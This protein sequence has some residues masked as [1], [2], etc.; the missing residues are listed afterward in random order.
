MRRLSHND[1]DKGAREMGQRCMFINGT[2]ASVSIHVYT[3][4][5]IRL[6]ELV[7]P[8]SA[9]APANA[10]ANAV[11]QAPTQAGPGSFVLD[12]PDG[13]I[14]GFSTEHTA[15]IQ[16]PQGSSLD[17]HVANGNVPW[18]DPPPEER[19][20]SASRIWTAGNRVKVH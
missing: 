1:R 14:C 9:N 12:I 5:V 8:A 13:V 17:V 4:D 20:Q 7:D 18:P 3:L 15:A 16:T 2:G 19:L 10:Q 6:Y 11:A